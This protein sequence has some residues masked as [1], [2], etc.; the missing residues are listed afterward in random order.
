MI[1]IEERTM[2]HSRFSGVVLA[3]ILMASNPAGAWPDQPLRLVVPFAAGGTTDVMA[4][5]IAERL[6]PHLGQPVVIENVPGSGGNTGAA[7]V[8][9]ATPNGS[10]ILM[11]TPGPA[12]MN[13][14]MYNRMP[15][16]TATAF[17]PIVYIASVPSVL[18]VSPKLNVQSVT[19]FISQM[20][21]RPEGA[22]F[23][24]AGMGSTG[25]LGGTLFTAST[26]LKAQHVPY[27]GSSPMLQDL[28]AGNIQFA[29]DTVPGLMSFVTSGTLKALAVTSKLRSPALPDVP[30]NA[31]AAIPGVEMSSWLALLAPA[32]TPRAVIDQINAAVNA[33]VGEP[34]L[35]QKIMDLGAVPEGG[36]PEDLAAFLHSESRKWKRVIEIAAVRIE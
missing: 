10:T 6:S 8:A 18:V 14:F 21:A 29:I 30:N 35:R 31:E 22:N 13:Q 16:D 5:V 15:F 33:A 24:S 26:G 36:S 12:A 28:I 20:K 32:G 11:A 9:K 2:S 17:A 4:R 1:L 27:R 34:Q 3:L 25:H 7:L 23:G 19:D